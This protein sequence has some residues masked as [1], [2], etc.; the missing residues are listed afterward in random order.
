MNKM[1]QSF[2]NNLKFPDKPMK[3]GDTFEQDMP[4]NIPGMGSDMK[5]GAKV[6]YKLISI[7]GGKANFNI[8]YN[9]NMDMAAGKSIPAAMH[10][11]GGGAGTMEY[12]IATNY[13]THYVQN[14]DMNM[15]IPA[16]AG[17]NMTMKMKM[18]MEQQTTLK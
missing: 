16:A 10:M 18:L 13:P 11:T 17:K 12:D 5:I 8:T 15:A 3:I 7:S 4:F 2:Q 1:V 9:M 6:S 14:M